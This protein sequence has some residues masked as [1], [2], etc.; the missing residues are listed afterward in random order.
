MD[1]EKNYQSLKKFALE[2]D[3]DLFGVADISEVKKNFH[4]SEKLLSKFDKAICIGARLSG[5]ILEE[6][7]DKP[8]RLYFYHYRMVNMLLDQAAL[9]ISRYIENKGFS[10][11]PIPS[12]QVLDWEK[13]TAHLSHRR[14]GYLAG[15]GWIGR[16]NLLVNKEL[17]SQFRL[18]TVLT[19]MP[20]KTDEPSKES[21]G[22][23]RLC[24]VKCPAGAIK[25]EASAFDGKKCYEKLRE[26]QRQRQIDQYVC[27]VC[28]NICRGNE[29]K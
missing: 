5:V 8:T 15:L 6:I 12:T 11:V 20:L 19:D 1:K 13:Q 27:G 21:C 29:K 17:G 23:C 2:Q 18:V 10:A 25:E 24:I 4:L 16:S 14:L 22:S 9:K 7:V 26:F 3:I 28:V